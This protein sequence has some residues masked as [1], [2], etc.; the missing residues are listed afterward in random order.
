MG[1]GDDEHAR[2]EA[3]F[4]A[5]EGLSTGEQEEA[6]RQLFEASSKLYSPPREPA[7]AALG[8]EPARKL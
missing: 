5:L 1:L 6:T 3:A 7:D 2:F 8:P 4:D